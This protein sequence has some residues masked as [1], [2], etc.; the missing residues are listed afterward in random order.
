MDEESDNNSHNNDDNTTNDSSDD[1]SAKATS[2]NASA[3]KRKLKKKRCVA[4]SLGLAKLFKLALRDLFY[5]KGANL[6]FNKNFPIFVRNIYR[7]LSVA[8][9]GYVFTVVCHFNSVGEGGGQHQRT[10]SQQL[11]P[12]WDL[13]MGPGHNTPS[14]RNV[15]LKISVYC[16]TLYCVL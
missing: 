15:T 9:E 5:S 6:A 1:D 13:D 14:P 10:W 16:L 8:S 7:P 3:V 2:S 12:P 11:T 4:S